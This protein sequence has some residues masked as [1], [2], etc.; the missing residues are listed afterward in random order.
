MKSDDVVA[1]VTAAA[2]RLWSGP[3]LGL[4]VGL[5]L[6]IALIAVAVR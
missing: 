2:R 4:C 5:V 3:F 6:G 1:T